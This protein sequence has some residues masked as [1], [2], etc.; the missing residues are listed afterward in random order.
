[1]ILHGRTGVAPEPEG[2]KP[3]LNFNVASLDAEDLPEDSMEGFQYASFCFGVNSKI[4]RNISSL[5]CVK[6]VPFKTYLDL[7]LCG[8]EVYADAVL[9]G[10][11]GER[12]F[13]FRPI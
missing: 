2:L 3:S 12:S 8:R 10:D 9:D 1:M 5:A 4:R 7:L 11:P 13:H 6:H